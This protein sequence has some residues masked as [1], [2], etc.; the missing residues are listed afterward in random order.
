MH[1][2]NDATKTTLVCEDVVSFLDIFYVLYACTRNDLLTCE[3]APNNRLNARSLGLFIELDGAVHAAV[4]GKGKR[5]HAAGL[6]RL[7]QPL[8]A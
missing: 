8:D 3:E 4:V 7:D 1:S 2:A 5:V 6:R